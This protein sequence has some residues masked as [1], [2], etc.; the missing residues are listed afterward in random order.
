MKN[1]NFMENAAR[2]IL[3]YSENSDSFEPF[4]KNR[5]FHTLAA[6]QR[7]MR[8]E[9]EEEKKGMSFPETSEEEDESNYFSQ[10]DMSYY[11]RMGDDTYSWE[12]NEIPVPEDVAVSSVHG[13]VEEKIASCIGLCEECSS[14]SCIFCPNGYCLLPLIYGRKPNV[15]EDDGCRDVLPKE[16]IESFH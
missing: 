13:G 6:A 12:I 14:E 7:A 8:E 2:F 10:T 9:V 1:V 3:T 4:S 11:V 16:L 15:S 5:Y